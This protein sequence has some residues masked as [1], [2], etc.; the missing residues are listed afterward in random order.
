MENKT[1]IIILFS[2][3]IFLFLII[4]LRLADI[5]LLRH[6]FYQQRSQQQRT[7]LIKLAAQ[8]GDVY[9]RQG[10]ILATSIDTYSLYKHNQGWL[11]RKLQLAAAEII[12]QKDPQGISLI[13]EKQRIYPK[14]RL[15]AQLMGFVG[16]DNQGLSGV[17]LAFDEYLRGKEGRLVTEGDP[18]GRELYGA[19][20][21]LEQGSDGMDVTL[22]IDENIQYV[23]EREIEKQIKQTR[24][25]SGLCLVMDAKTGE[26]LALASKPDFDPNAYQKT[27]KQLW[28]LRVLDPYEPGST[29]KVITVAAALAEGVVTLQTKLQAMDSII[30]GGKKI[31]NSLPIDWT[32]KWTTISQMLEKSIN[33]GSVQVGIKLGP[34]KFY[35][36]IKAFGFGERTGFGLWGE[37]KGIVRHWQRWY[38]PDIGMITFG[39]SIAVTP[40][41]L[42]S[43]VSTFAKDGVM[44]SPI[45]IKRI[46][47]QDGKFVKVFTA[48]KKRVISEQ[49]ASEVKDLMRNVVLNGSG[50]RA[51]INGF[52]VCGKTGTA[53]KANLRGHGYFKDRFI[54]SFV[55]FAPY[56]D[57][58]VVALVILDDPKG[59]IWGGSTCGPVFK[60]VV[61]YSLR[62]LNAKPDVL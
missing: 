16:V 3:F 52:S 33:T 27:D 17:E 18:R 28:H 19:L 22:T 7:R 55:G 13:K 1:R 21:E 31:T 9:D 45:L 36:Q 42:L 61:E 4:G 54:A 49:V 29:F 24:S 14:G 11:A 48:R 62:Y 20:R 50:K 34:E 60:D 10:N 40:L 57:P 53:Q 26:I 6:Q 2:I 23:A 32:G 44:V 58:A 56:E 25:S 39:Q 46:E 5:Q 43:A 15:A 37:S 51:G 30:I 59:N 47:S 38:K 35:R 8:R 41:Q 12:Q